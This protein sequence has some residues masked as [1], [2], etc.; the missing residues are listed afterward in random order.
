MTKPELDNFSAN[1]VSLLQAGCFF[2]ALAAAPL[3]DKF[4]RRIGLLASAIF[5]V[6]GSAMQT[7]AAGQKS[8]LFAGRAIG[9]LGVGAASSLVPLFV[10]ESSPAN[11]RGRL[12]GIYEIG[13]QF[14]T[15]IGFWIN[16]GVSQHIPSSNKQWMIPFAIQ[17]IPGGLLMLG[18]MLLPESPR[19]I[20]KVKGA[21][22]AKENMARSFNLPVDSEYIQY[23]VNHVIAQINAERTRVGGDGFFAELKEIFCLPLNRKRLGLGVM[24]FIFMQFTGSNAINYYSPRVFKSIG[25]NSDTT[26]ILTGVYGTVRFITVFFTSWFLVDRFGRTN[27]MLLG[28][29]GMVSL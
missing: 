3:A 7:W 22:A 25:I 18:V 24:I 8:L 21:Q 16:Y 15:L 17:L 10:A 5:F 4:G 20:A 28:S 9:G 11:I 29:I 12:V 1:V 2:G 19:W 26:L 23:E 27:L 13:V 6:I 14:G